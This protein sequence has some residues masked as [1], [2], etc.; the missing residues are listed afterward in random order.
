MR[1]KGLLLIE[2]KAP[3]HTTRAQ[4]LSPPSGRASGNAE[5]ATVGAIEYPASFHYQWIEKKLNPPLEG[6][7][8]PFVESHLAELVSSREVMQWSS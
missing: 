1:V 8:A 4:T 5:Y 6:G 2:K 3:L 7:G